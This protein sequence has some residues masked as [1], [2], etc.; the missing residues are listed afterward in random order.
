MS[1]TVAQTRDASRSP[2]RLVLLLGLAIFINYIDRGNLAT[3]APVMRGE[4]HLSL[5]QIGILIS[6]FYWTYTPMQ[7]VSGWVAER[8]NASKV[9]A[10]GFALWSVAT[11][12]TGVASGFAV[13]LGLR[14]LLGLGESVYFPCSGE[15]LCPVHGGRPTR[16]GKRGR[17]EW[18]RI[19]ACVRRVRRG[20]DPGAIRVAPAVH[21]HGCA[22]AVV[23]LAMAGGSG[24][25]HHEGRRR[26]DA[27]AGPMF[28]EIIG[29]RELWG[30]SLFHFCSNYGLYLL[31]SWLPTYLVQDRGL[32]IT[33]MAVLGGEVY[34]VMGSAAFAAGWAVDRWIRSGATPNRAYKT[35]MVV[36]QSAMVLCLVGSGDRVGGSV[37]AL[38]ALAGGVGRWFAR[39]LCR[40][41]DHGGSRGGRSVD[42][43]PELRRQLGRHTWADHHRRTRRSERATSMRHLYSPSS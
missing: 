43:I 10:V 14:L 18:S 9:I 24:A 20:T 28:E 41:S 13:L 26:S 30:A 4:L 35:I 22:V 23:A 39:H 5:P 36:G 21:R 27:P 3:A 25:P 7:L 40:R 2:P 19:R 6:A 42:G 16:A 37:L 38:L 32:S 1:G 34:L 11:M 33:R 8:F 29:R 31:V 15:A 12:L 17:G